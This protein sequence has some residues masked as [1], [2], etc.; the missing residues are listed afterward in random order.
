MG[1]QLVLDELVDFDL[2]N[3]DKNKRKENEVNV[4]EY[5]TSS[6]CLGFVL[7]IWPMR[8]NTNFN[9]GLSKLCSAADLCPCFLPIDF[10][11]FYRSRQMGLYPFSF[12][13][14]GK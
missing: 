7:W 10:T 1:Y 9:G 11:H 6:S 8:S 4:K 2:N 3:F 5:P 13:N 12:G 14:E